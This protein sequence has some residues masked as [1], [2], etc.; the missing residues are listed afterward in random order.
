MV[1]AGVKDPEITA[2]TRIPSSSSCVS[3]SPS[4]KQSPLTSRSSQ[5]PERA[6]FWLQNELREYLIRYDLSIEGTREDLT[7][8]CETKLRELAVERAQAREVLAPEFKGEPEHTAEVGLPTDVPVSTRSTFS[9]DLPPPHSLFKRVFRSL[10]GFG[11][12]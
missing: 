11:P 2:E 10:L 5:L 9:G 3:P 6:Q 8:C 4:G 1:A 12:S 7:A